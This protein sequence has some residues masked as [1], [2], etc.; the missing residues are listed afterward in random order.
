ML[1]ACCKTGI[2]T[3]VILRKNGQ[4]ITTNGRSAVSGDA[5]GEVKPVCLNRSLLGLCIE[6]HRLR[7][8]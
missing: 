3:L 8:S 6:I 4:V 5:D 7:F 2:P 1:M